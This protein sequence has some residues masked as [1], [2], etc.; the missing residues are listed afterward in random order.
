MTFDHDRG[1]VVLYGGYDGSVRSD[2]WEWDGA[3][4]RA[5]DAQGGPQLLHT[6]MVYDPTEGRLL[7][8][9]GFG[10]RREGG[11]WSMSDGRWTRLEVEGPPA[12]AEHEGAFVPGIGFVVFGGIGGQGMSLAERE[13]LNDLWIFDGTVW[14]KWI[15]P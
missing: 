1:V 3:T 11:T 10:E 14:Q 15:A 6:A 9:G 5:V 2:V 13:K 4:W 8:F 7:V 12:R